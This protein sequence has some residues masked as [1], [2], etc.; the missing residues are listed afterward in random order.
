[1]QR[2]RRT[3]KVALNNSNNRRLFM[4]D[5]TQRTIILK[6][7]ELN[8]KLIEN[9]TNFAKLLIS[10]YPLMFTT[11][12]SARNRISHIV[13][14]REKKKKVLLNEKSNTVLAFS[15]F[16][17]PYEDK[18]A[19]DFLKGVADKY[20]P[21]QIVCLGDIA[22]VHSTS[23]H[24][25]NPNLYGPLDELNAATKAIS[26][27]Y[28][29]FPDMTITVGNHDRKYARKMQ[30]ASI[31][32]RLLVPLNQIW[33]T[34]KWNW[35]EEVYIDGVRY[36]HADGASHAHLNAYATGISH[37]QGHLHSRFESQSKYIRCFDK[38]VFGAT[39][40]CLADADSL[41]MAYAKNARF[42]NILGCSIIK[43]GEEIKLI[44]MEEV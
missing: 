24:E 25:V 34:P 38:V 9:K 19:V 26:K 14:K 1:M 29:E 20:Q 33:G 22:D 18:R 32:S 10:C 7:L 8:P 15:C 42:K 21:D 2:I 12:E 13:N 3:T 44:K 37:V 39:I 17:A 23:Y 6:T 11:V 27:L 36:F 28:K 4:N 16:H 41:A 35:V 5:N 30:T 43:N 31:P 40:G